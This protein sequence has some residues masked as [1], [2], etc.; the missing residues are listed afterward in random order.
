[1]HDNSAWLHD[2]NL[3]EFAAWTELSCTLR[4]HSKLHD[5]F[6]MTPKES[7]CF[8]GGGKWPCILKG[9]WN[10]SG[11]RPFEKQPIVTWLARRLLC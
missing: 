3:H 7:F 4:W 10:A 1:V 8:N 9:R 5:Y 11:K 2:N 6:C